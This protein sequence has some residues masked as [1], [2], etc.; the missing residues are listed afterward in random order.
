MLV[1]EQ[2]PNP[3]R[4]FCKASAAETAG[5]D[6]WQIPV[7]NTR[8]LFSH[9]S[10]CFNMNA[11]VRNSDLRAERK[12]KHDSSTTGLARG[13]LEKCVSCRRAAYFQT[14]SLSHQSSQVILWQ[15]FCFIHQAPGKP[16]T[17]ALEVTR[18]HQTC[19]CK[20]TFTL[21]RLY[22]FPLPPNLTQ[23]LLSDGWPVTM[24]ENLSQKFRFSRHVIMSWEK[25]PWN[26]A[27]RVVMVKNSQSSEKFGDAEIK[28]LS[29]VISIQSLD[30]IIE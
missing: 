9:W 3:L 4:P 1:L 2:I 22:F 29:G 26:D 17:S 30:N 21:H 20:S 28:W 15:L 27:E 14:P 16:W 6:W 18:W 23:R 19:I 8:Q 10:L 24:T 5:D 12:T 25:R 13:G 7:G 11:L